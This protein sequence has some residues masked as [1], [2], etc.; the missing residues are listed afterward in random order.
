VREGRL[1]GIKFVLCAQEQPQ[2]DRDWRIFVEEAELQPLGLEHI[3]AYL[4]K[5]GVEE[6]QRKAL[7]I[8]LLGNTKGKI[9][10]IAEQVDSF[11]ALLQKMTKR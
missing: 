3:E 7:A 11:L 6:E 1:T 9:S 5:R 2:L 4:E 8:M 10:L